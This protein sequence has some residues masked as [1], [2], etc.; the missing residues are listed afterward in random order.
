MSRTHVLWIEQHLAT[1]HKAIWKAANL[2]EELPDQGLADD[3][4]D[5]NEEVR[6]ILEDMLKGRPRRR[7]S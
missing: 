2:A 7:S 5:L 6:R 3:L 1:A 4:H